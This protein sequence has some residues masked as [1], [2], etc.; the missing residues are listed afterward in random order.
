MKRKKNKY[1]LTPNLIDYEYVGINSG[2]KIILGNTILKFG[3]V[4]DNMVMALIA[5]DERWSNY[6]QKTEQVKEV[7]PAKKGSNKD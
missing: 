5:Q 1:V 3:T 4:N 7:K 2:K 6:F